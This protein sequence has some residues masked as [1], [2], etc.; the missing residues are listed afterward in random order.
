MTATFSRTTKTCPV[1]NSTSRKI[2]DVDHYAI[3][4]CHVCGHQFTDLLPSAEHVEDVFDDR[5]FAGYLK[6]AKFLRLKG[7]RYA[8]MID[9]YFKK[10]G[11]FFDV[12]AA[13][14][15]VM[16]AF[17]DR[18]WKGSG[19]EPNEGMVAL[20]QQAG[21]RVMQ[22]TMEEFRTT[23]K[24]DLVTFI[25][26]VSHF[27]DVQEAF[28]VAAEA[29]QS[30]GLWLIETGNRDSLKA[31]LWGERWADY[32]PPSLLHWFSPKDL[33][34]LVAQFGFQE[35]ARG[36]PRR[37]VNAG[38][39]KLTLR[40]QK[41]VLSLLGLLLL[42]LVPNQCPIPYPAHDQFWVIYKKLW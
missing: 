41:G 25:Q 37:W 32:D 34:R 6:E 8:R 11:R 3:R 9:R 17:V 10:P 29:T 16:Q 4:G 38:H 35:I 22:G 28:R 18:D 5:Y 7:Q 27:T 21:L 26:V 39:A 15:F 36:K 2:F 13:A 23:E 31:R 33:Q 1:C 12:G 19:I 30:N 42:A 14:G 20:A 40:R 24:Y